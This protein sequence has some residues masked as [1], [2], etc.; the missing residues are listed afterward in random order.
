MSSD[1]RF[2]YSRRVVV[3][4]G[5]IGLV[6]A[7]APA[8]AQ[9]SKESPLSKGSDTPAPEALQDARN[10]HAKPPFRRQ[11]QAWPGLARKMVPGREHGEPSYRGTGRVAGRKALITGGDSGM[12]RTAAIAFARE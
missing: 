6:A 12:G 1:P 2:P 9:R 3:G 8:F 7:A 4:A 11:E 5:G 10:K